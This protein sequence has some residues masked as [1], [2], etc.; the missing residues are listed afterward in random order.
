VSGFRFICLCWV[1][2]VTLCIYGIT[3]FEVDVVGL[4]VCFVFCIG[5]LCGFC[6]VLSLVF[7]LLCCC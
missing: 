3:L 7:S 5:C 6:G 4:F 1:G 2:F